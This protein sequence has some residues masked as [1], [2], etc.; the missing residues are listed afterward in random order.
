[1]LFV[2]VFSTLSF[3]SSN[4]SVTQAEAKKMG[5]GHLLL[6]LAELEY[7]HGPKKCVLFRGLQNNPSFIMI[8]GSNA[9][10]GKHVDCDL[11][12]D[13][14]SKPINQKGA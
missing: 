7:K 11:I 2:F 1:M 13:L 5:Y 3:A 12:M 4:V 8:D 6:T 10:R 14:D 9:G